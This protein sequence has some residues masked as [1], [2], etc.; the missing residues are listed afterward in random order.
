MQQNDFPPEEAIH[1]PPLSHPHYKAYFFG[2]FRVMCDGQDLGTPTWR[3]NKARTLLKWFLLNPGSLFSVEQLN[4]L[5]WPHVGEKVATSNLHV[6]M[7]YLRHILEPELAPGN[8]S[9]FIRRNRHNYY[10]FDLNDAWW[11]DVSE[12]RQLS[13]LAREAESRG[14]IARSAAL[15]SQVVGYYSQ[16]FL[17]ED[18]YD[19]IFSP[20]RR[21]F[22]F[23]YIQI[24]EHLLHLHTQAGQP[25]EAHTCA[26]RIL[27][28]DPYN[29]TAMAV[30]VQLSLLQGNTI[31]ALR[32]IDDFGQALKQDLGIEPGRE[33]LAL[34]ASILK[35]T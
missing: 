31:S 8:A 20:H 2:S 35:S 17:P 18:I 15:Y 28:A 22:D 19:D 16:G 5:F 12:V 25:D 27:S 32:Q 30:I 9:I 11:T 3:R 26:L 7:H 23:A 6:T 34:R 14:E 24:L 1:Y 21:Q 33:M 13:T 4:K 29:E 10:W